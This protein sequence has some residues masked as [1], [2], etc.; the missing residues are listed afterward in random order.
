MPSNRPWKNAR[1]VRGPR[2]DAA[3]RAPDRRSE[4]ARRAS[5]GD[6][7][8]GPVA[9]SGSSERLERRICSALKKRRARR[10]AGVRGAA[11]EPAFAEPMAID[12]MPR[13]KRS[14]APRVA[15]GS[16]S[17]RAPSPHRRPHR[18]RWRGT[19]RS[20]PSCRRR[21]RVRRQAELSAISG[22]TRRSA[23]PA[24]RRRAAAPCRARGR[25]I[26]SGQRRATGS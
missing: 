1:I 12:A 2:R 21:R 4:S 8:R 11:G 3:V 26:Q 25:A 24:R 22:A 5:A 18:R 23:F 10:A 16:A 19:R 17:C 6:N 9:R 15:S 13:A 20:H 14:A 7:S